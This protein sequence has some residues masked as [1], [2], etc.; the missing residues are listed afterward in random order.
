ML[1]K[2]SSDPTSLDQLVR[3]TGLE[4]PALC[5]GLERLAQAG[6]AR[7]LGG[8]WERTRS[9]RRS[10]GTLSATSLDVV[11]LRAAAQQAHREGVEVVFLA[12]GRWGMQS[13]WRPG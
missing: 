10:G 6:V 7:D 2:L 9:V 3:L 4:L 13:C 11:A 1:D 5:G 12:E 8:W